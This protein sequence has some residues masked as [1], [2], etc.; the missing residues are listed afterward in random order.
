MQRS[1]QRDSHGRVIRR[2]DLL[3]FFQLRHKFTVKMPARTV[4]RQLV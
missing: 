3:R 2:R 1:P 4:N